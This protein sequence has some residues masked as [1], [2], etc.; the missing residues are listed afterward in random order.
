MPI[1]FIKEIEDGSTLALWYIDEEEV[2]LKKGLKMSEAEERELSNIRA[3]YGRI[4]WLA[5]RRALNSLFSQ[6]ITECLKDEHGKPFVK[7]FDGY[8]SLS[9][10]NEYAIAIMHP[11]HPVG[12]DI[13]IVQ[14]KIKRIKRKFMTDKELSFI[15]EEH[16]IEQLYACWCAKE[17]IFKWQGRKGISLKQ[18]IDIVPFEY[19]HEGQLQARLNTSEG[20]QLLTVEYEKLEGYFLAY[21]SNP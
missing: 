21:V 18:N 8:I 19:Q 20:S 5:V 17:S 12:V 2:V 14:P 15:Q 16:E 7:D 11:E 9:H 4:R 13:E 1:R 3:P 10:S 6:D